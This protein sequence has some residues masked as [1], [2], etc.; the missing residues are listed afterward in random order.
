MAAFPA[1]KTYFLRS[2]AIITWWYQSLDSSTLSTTFSITST[3]CAPHHQH[4]RPQT[5]TQLTAPSLRP[6]RI[7]RPPNRAK[8]PPKTH[9][10][11]SLLPHNPTRIQRLV[12]LPPLASRPS[13]PSRNATLRTKIQFLQLRTR[14]TRIRRARWREFRR[15]RCRVSVDEGAGACEEGVWDRY[16]GRI[17]V[18]LGRSF[19]LY[20]IASYSVLEQLLISGLGWIQ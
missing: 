13:P 2:N 19:S 10:P 20:V 6:R 8:A 3:I 12:P 1:F 5:T 4:P 9:N 17:G 14:G 16:E 11:N 15:Y 7:P 18:C